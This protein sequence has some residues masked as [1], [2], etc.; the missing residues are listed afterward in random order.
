MD[1][2]FPQPLGPNNPTFY[3][4]EFEINIIDSTAFFYISFPKIFN[5]NK[6]FIMMLF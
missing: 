5:L 6:H 3:F 4:F 1:V 2:V